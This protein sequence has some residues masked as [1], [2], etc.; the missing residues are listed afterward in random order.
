MDFVE[1]GF[2]Y[3]MTDFQAALL[4]GQI[5]RLSATLARKRAIAVCYLSEI[6]NQKVTLPSVPEDSE[7]SWQTFHLLLES[8]TQRD[9]L[10]AH[11]RRSGIMSNYGAQ[12]IPAMRYYKKKYGN[13]FWKEFPDAFRAYACG[14]AIPLYDKLSDEQAKRV[15]D[16]INSF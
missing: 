15:I 6:R 11:L 4:Y 3:R 5:K 1:A 9:A 8:E 14:L 2:N 7:H 13:N 12:C 10:S 16:S